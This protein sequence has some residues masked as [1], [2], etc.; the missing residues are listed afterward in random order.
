MDNDIFQTLVT[1]AGS[2]VNLN[3]LNPSQREAVTST[4]GPLL[5]IA[6]AGSGKTRTLVYRV[7]YL[8]EQG[9][10][11]EKILLLTFTRKASQEMLWRAGLLL[12][13]TCRKVVG[14]TFH[15]IANMLLRR[16]GHHL[17][18]GS[19]F[20]IIDRADAEGIVNLLK[21]SLG[22]T[23]KDKQFPTKRVLINILSGSVNKSIAIDDLIYESYSHLSEHVDDIV[24]LEKHYQEFKFNNGLMDYDDLLV[25]WKRL[26]DEVPEARQEIAARYSHIMVDEYQDTN[27]IQAEIVRLLAYGH[28]NV[29]VVGDD[30]QSI[31]SF[32]G[33]D[34]YNIM[35]FPKVFSETKIIKLEENY[36]SCQ[37]I[38]SLTNDIIRNASEKYA[39]TLFTR[40][41]GDEKPRLFAGRD[42]R[43]EAVFVSK[44]I[45]ELR[46]NGI[47]LSN[48]AVLFR[49]GFHSYKL[50]MELNSTG[51]EFEKRGGLK[52]TESAHMKDVIA[53]LRLRVNP[54]D[55]LS[56]NRI[57]LHLDKVGP[58]TAR[59]I[60]D[61]IARGDN[62]G[63]TLAEFPC[64]KSWAPGVAKL[65]QLFVDME[66]ETAPGTLYELV[67][68]HYQPLFEKIYR[69]DFPKRQKDL[70]Q[71]KSI[72][73]GYDDVQGFVDDT[74]LDP[75]ETA[76][77]LSRD[78]KERMI[79][80]TIHSSKG[81]EW[82][83]VFVMGLADGRFPH[84]AAAIGEQWEEERRLLYVAATRA[85]KYLYLTYPRE[86]MT[87]DRQFRRVGMSPF[88]S[89]LRAGLF[90]RI[91]NNGIQRSRSSF[92]TSQPAS[93]N[94]MTL[95]GKTKKTKL[96]AEDL[97]KGVRVKHPFFGEGV[98]QDKPKGRSVN[99]AFQRH[100]IKTLHLDYAKL[101]IR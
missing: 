5:V 64:G 32:R 75:P 31:Y 28:E 95:P 83:A 23:G 3:E 48:I 24:N 2:S 4:E 36:R 49:S 35:R 14:G 52:L 26:L 45:A 71:L 99:V 85:R 10:D 12:N 76:K 82:D 57:L 37:P 46:G 20:T 65:A 77:G 40:I 43:E 25:N 88:L 15:G 61:A 89:E 42:E 79:L 62:P 13:E 60:T 29:M 39:K 55:T 87:P 98:V 58:K 34:F 59:K 17:G 73:A 54:I 7:A 21:G 1:S 90:E 47:E 38:L 8:L 66:K 51:V 80:S 41:E 27:L 67:W 11:P 69:D 63:Q 101:S 9:V 33:A 53:F 56:W 81:L 50:E 84:T 74:T 22:L 68:A 19:S 30:S 97:K 70:D 16:H 100:G 18:F 96:S 92:V 78:D 93:F 91:D 94:G 72:I 86:L 6:G 44:K